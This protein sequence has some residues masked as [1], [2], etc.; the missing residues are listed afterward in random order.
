MD[1]A[2]WY[3]VALQGGRVAGLR[4][5]SCSDTDGWS[6]SIAQLSLGMLFDGQK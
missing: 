5:G 2:R 4:G 3:M 6:K 1:L